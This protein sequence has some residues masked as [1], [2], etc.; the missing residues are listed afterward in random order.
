MQNVLHFHRKCKSNGCIFRDSAPSSAGRLLASRTLSA[1]TRPCTPARAT[2][3]PSR[4][5]G[6][7]KRGFWGGDT[8]RRRWF[9]GAGRRASERNLRRTANR[10]LRHT[11]AGH[12]KCPHSDGFCPCDLK[13]IAWVPRRRR[14]SVIRTTTDDYGRLRTNTG[15][16]GRGRWA[17]LVRDPRRLCQSV[18]VRVSPCPA[19]LISA[20]SAPDKCPHVAARTPYYSV[21][22]RTFPAHTAVAFLA[23]PTRAA[24]RSRFS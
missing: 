3:S 22:I 24:R 1:G 7:G 4:D 20:R 8:V 17:H 12:T 2:M 23:A 18:S 6:G 9:S 14:Q 5:W 16:V 21:P 15:C 11:R 19:P 13:Q 10:R